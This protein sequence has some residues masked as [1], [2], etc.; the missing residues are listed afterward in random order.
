MHVVIGGAF[1]GKRDWVKDKYKNIPSFEWFDLIENEDPDLEKTEKKL[2][3]FEGIEHWTRKFLEIYS[4]NQARKIG[5]NWISELI[6]WEEQKEE[7]QIV[8]IA[9]DISKGIVPIE[10]KDRDWRDLTG[11][12]YQDLIEKADEV[13]KIW[14]GIAE[15]LK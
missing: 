12:F 13:D 3:V 14:Y 11:W 2:L 5:S 1:N 6:H 7:R 10:K 8:L 9:T 15:K 4:I